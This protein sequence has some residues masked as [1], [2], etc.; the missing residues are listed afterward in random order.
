MVEM[1][2]LISWP[3]AD[4]LEHLFK[5]LHEMIQPDLLGGFPSRILSTVVLPPRMDLLLHGDHSAG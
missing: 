4:I 2:L 5:E 3:A 1:H